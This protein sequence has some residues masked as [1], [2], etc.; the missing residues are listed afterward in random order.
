MAGRAGS[1][2]SGFWGFR[3]QDF[4]GYEAITLVIVLP[5]SFYI[6]ILVLRFICGDPLIGWRPYSSSTA[7]IL[8]GFVLSPAQFYATCPF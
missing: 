7:T 6:M 1:Q 8:Q 5:Y 4:S 2:V 3:A